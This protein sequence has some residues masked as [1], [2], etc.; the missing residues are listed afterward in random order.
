MP[1]SID[2]QVGVPVGDQLTCCRLDSHSTTARNSDRHSGAAHDCLR[3]RK[4][5]LIRAQLPGQALPVPELHKLYSQQLGNCVGS[6]SK[7]GLGPRP[8]QL[9]A[10]P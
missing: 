4:Q 7:H 1:H 8:F 2:M 3:Q 5:E 9:G 10:Q 6:T